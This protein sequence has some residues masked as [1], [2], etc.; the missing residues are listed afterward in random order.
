MA[1]I[2]R[3]LRELAFLVPLTVT[4]YNGDANCSKSREAVASDA[5]TS[6]DTHQTPQTGDKLKFNRLYHRHPDKLTTPFVLVLADN[7][8][9]HAATIQDLPAETEQHDED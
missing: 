4:G 2:E 6:P 9:I 8:P 7:P 5:S 3:T 1:R